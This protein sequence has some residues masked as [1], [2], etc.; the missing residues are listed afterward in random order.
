MKNI[1]VLL[2]LGISTIATAQSLKEVSLPDFIK[3]ILQMKKEEKRTQLIWWLPAEYW[4]ISISQ[5]S[6]ISPDVAAEINATVK[7]YVIVCVN[8]MVSNGTA[9]L[10]YKTEKEIL[11]DFSLVDSSNKVFYPLLE[12]E[13]S[14]EGLRLKERFTPLFMRTL[15]QLG[16][17]MS[18]FFF[19][20]QD[21]HGE[22]II[23]ARKN[24]TFKIIQ[25]GKTFAWDLPLST[26]VSPKFCPIDNQQMNGK[27]QYCPMHGVKLKN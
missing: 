8:D 17:G 24:G 2:L 22:N 12:N 9:P 19:K 3:E 13:I 21:E 4:A 23:D 10:S 15:G 14:P 27:W 18:V 11:A 25:G 5:I 1:L 26:L 20:V 7:D 16:A 6:S